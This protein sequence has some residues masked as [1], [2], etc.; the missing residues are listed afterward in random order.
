MKRFLVTLVSLSIAA[1]LCFPATVRAADPLQRTAIIGDSIT[2]GHSASS[3]G[4][5]YAGLLD[6]TF[7]A[8]GRDVQTFAVNGATAL[9]WFYCPVYPTMRGCESPEYIGQYEKLKAYKPATVLIALG[10]NEMIISRPASTFASHMLQL[11]KKVHSLV[12]AGTNI[13]FVRYYDITNYG[14]QPTA[15]GSLCD[16]PGQCSGGWQKPTWAQY[17]NALTAVAAPN[18]VSFIDIAGMPLNKD[19][20]FISDHVHLNDSGHTIYY[21]RLNDYLQQVVSAQA[22]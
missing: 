11:A 7:N 22:R 5:S 14:F 16:F 6:S 1:A 18:G 12:P 8:Q 21:N 4:K 2:T 20:D 17:G 15:P 13:A 9:R 19:A 10:G 3:P